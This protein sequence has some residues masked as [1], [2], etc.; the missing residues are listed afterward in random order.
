VNKKTLSDVDPASLRS[1]NVVVRADL[2]VPIDDGEITDDQRIEAAIPSLRAL[3][4]AGARVTILSHLGRPKGQPNPAFTLEPVARRL[5]SLM[6]R[7]VAFIPTTSARVARA[8]IEELPDGVLALLENTRFEPGE[9]AN[10]PALAES[11]ATLG[12]LFVN[13]A[14]GTAHRAHAST[15]GL[16]QAM[17]KRGCEAVAGQLMALELRFLE[18]SLR[19]PKRPFVAIIG[20]AKISSKIGVISALLPRV[21]RLLVGGAMANTFFRALGLDTGE[22]LVEEDSIGVAAKLIEEGGESLVLPT[23]CIVASELSESAVTRV[24]ARSGVSGDDK[25]LDIGPESRALF[26]EMV[27]RAGTIVWN[28]PMG[29]F[30]VEPFAAG[31]LA[32]AEAVADACDG[33][34][35]GVVGGGDSAAAA[36]QAGLVE[37]LTHV[38]TGGGASLELLA[39][40]ELPGVQSLSDT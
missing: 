22:S 24:A 13:D 25:I 15:A 28:G 1:R 40:A 16:A 5:S 38:S 3:A 32:V 37:R 17:R 2:N 33:G 12:D 31:T 11:W 23:D 8:A 6:G 10:D 35:L 9:T 18:E 36:E 26:A 21:D 20:G 39:G 19:M 14:F 34:A 29:V 4:D 27:R 7:P 30:E